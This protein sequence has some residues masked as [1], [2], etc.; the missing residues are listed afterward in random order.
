MFDV[1]TLVNWENKCQE[2]RGW[3]QGRRDIVAGTPSRLRDMLMGEP[4]VKCGMSKG[5][6]VRTLLYY[7]S[8]NEEVG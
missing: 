6:V 4:E 2:M 5:Q 7:Y 3:M 8:T 1:R